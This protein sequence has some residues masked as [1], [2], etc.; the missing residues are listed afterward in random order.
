[1]NIQPSFPFPVAFGFIGILLFQVVYLGVVFW[2]VW[3]FLQTFR[4][5][6]RSL[7]R[8]ADSMWHINETLRGL[9]GRN[10]GE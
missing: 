2:L 8:N 9:S 1:M 3:Q 10:R 7:E 4:G 6:A 5:I